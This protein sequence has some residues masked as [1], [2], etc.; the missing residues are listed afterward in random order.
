MYLCVCL[1]VP[2]RHSVC[3]SQSGVPTPVCNSP[4]TPT[5]QNYQTR[6]DNVVANLLDGYETTFPL[7][8]FL[9]KAAYDLKRSMASREPPPAPDATP[10]K[11]PRV[12]HGTRK[13]A[14]RTAASKTAY[15]SP[16]DS[17]GS[18]VGKSHPPASSKARRYARASQ[19]FRRPSSVPEDDLT[20]VTARR[21]SGVSR[22]DSRT[23]TPAMFMDTPAPSPTFVL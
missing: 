23:P 6:M 13:A 12:S 2:V 10:A 8:L 17:A 18:T 3:F 16:A 21:M 20:P 19:R 9:E 4:A 7:E 11:E 22:D 1:N 14:L 5:P 15:W